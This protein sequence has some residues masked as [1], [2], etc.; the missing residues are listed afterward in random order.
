MNLK[1][2]GD[3]LDHWKLPKFLPLIHTAQFTSAV[4]ALPAVGCCYQGIALRASL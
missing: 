2:L 1:Y 4:T 3:A